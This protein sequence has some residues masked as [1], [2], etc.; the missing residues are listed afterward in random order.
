MEELME[1]GYLKQI[2][3]KNT[4]I[5]IIKTKDSDSST[6]FKATIH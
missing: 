1:W 2:R 3:E 4:T 5:K 6:I